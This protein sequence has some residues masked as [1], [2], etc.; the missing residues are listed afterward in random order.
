MPLPGPPGRDS[1]F[2]EGSGGC[3]GVLNTLDPRAN[4]LLQ[5]GIEELLLAGKVRVDRAL[6]ETGVLCYFVEG[7]L[8]VA[9]AGEG[10]GCGLEQASSHLLTLGAPL[11][12]HRGSQKLRSA[13]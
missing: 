3:D 12:F 4:A 13:P 9:A 10:A 1:G 11:S 5:E 8:G 6:G 2:S 7:R